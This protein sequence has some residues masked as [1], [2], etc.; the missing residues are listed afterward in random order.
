MGVV[1]AVTTVERQPAEILLIDEDQACAASAAGVLEAAGYSVHS[2]RER[3]AALRCARLQA[4]D[5]VIC[6]VNLGG[7][8]G[9]DLCREIRKLPGMLDVPVMFVSSAQA[10]DIVRRSHEAGGAY[11]LRK[12]LDSEVLLDLVGKALWL[13]HLVQ[14]RLSMHQAAAHSVPP[15]QKKPAARSAA[16]QGLRMPLA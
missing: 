10:P 16:V 13:P 11:Y 4:V 3:S 2:A 9:L 5:L 15:P 12:P 7:Q 6:D 14:S 8:S 1:A